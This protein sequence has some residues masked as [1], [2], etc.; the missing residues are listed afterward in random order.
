MLL[1]SG[2][3]L[4]IYLSI[5]RYSTSS[6]PPKP[7]EIIC[8]NQVSSILN[9]CVYSEALKKVFYIFH[10]YHLDQI[11][12]D[13]IRS[14]QSIPVRQYLRFITFD[15]HLLLGAILNYIICTCASHWFNQ[16]QPDATVA[17]S[18]EIFEFDEGMEFVVVFEVGFIVELSILSYLS[19]CYYIVRPINVGTVKST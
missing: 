10:S 13:Q 6:L 17:E 2:L 5:F 16:G 11:R 18:K 14:D 12:S 8:L 3:F 15:V 1:K 7:Q 4:F 19:G 9:S